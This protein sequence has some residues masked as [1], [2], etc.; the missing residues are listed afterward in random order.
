MLLPLG[1]VA[2]FLCAADMSRAVRLEGRRVWLR[3]ASMAALLLLALVSGLATDVFDPDAAKAAPSVLLAARRAALPWLW[4]LRGLG[5]ALLVCFVA[6]HRAPRPDP[7]VGPD[8]PRYPS[9]F[10]PP[11]FGTT[12]ALPRR[13]WQVLGLMVAASFFDA[14]DKALF[15]VALVQIQTGLGMEEAQ[16]GVLGGVVRLGVVPGVLLVLLAD[17]F[18]RRRVLL[19]SILGYTLMTGATALAPNPEWFVACQFGVRLFGTAEEVLATVVIAEEIDARHR[20]WALGLLAALMG[21]GAGLA[22]IAFAFVDVLPFGWRSLYAV[23]L[24]PLLLLAWLRRRLPETQR[25]ERYR[26]ESLASGARTHVLRPL[27]ALVRAYPARFAAV[28]AVVF[29]TS[30]SGQSAGFF[31]P[32]FV[33][34]AHGLAPAQFTLFGIA[35]GALSLVAAP[36]FG[37]LG[38][39]IG[40]RPIAILFVAANPISVMVLY[41]VPG[42][43]LLVV[44]AATTML[45]DAGADTNLG[46]FS[47][48]LFPTS[49]RST[50]DAARRL[51]GQVGGS[52]GLA[53]ESLLFAL[54][55]SHA[56]AITALAATGLLV[57]L[58]VARTYPETRGRVLEEISPERDGRGPPRPGERGRRGPPSGG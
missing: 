47:K 57:P 29:L 19:G 10:V 23:G 12:P 22:W 40:R 11:I 9:R 34:E 6:A 15:T 54:L 37:R 33:Q 7:G 8:A 43:F 41:H 38:D 21:L 18:G 51:V 26:A 53:C 1:T 58:L 49:H 50:A 45:S 16:L 32:K 13:Q 35:V 20:G 4:V 3:L 52:L 39:R 31:L 2:F 28:S 48:E 30:F 27:G 5:V 42:L 46:V 25:F 56:W 44:L 17:T 55:G 14:Y 36:L 24:G